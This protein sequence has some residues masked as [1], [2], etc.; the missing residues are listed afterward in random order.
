MS[1]KNIQKMLRIDKETHEILEALVLIG[2]AS[3]Q[4]KTKKEVVEKAIKNSVIA[5]REHY[6]D[7]VMELIEKNL[8]DDERDFVINKIF[9]DDL[10]I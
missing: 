1:T 8:S 4:A 5:L 2:K 6:H 7:V 10:P 9:K 3:G